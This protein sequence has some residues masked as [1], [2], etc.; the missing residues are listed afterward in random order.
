MV[1]F[2]FPLLTLLQP[3]SYP[4]PSISARIFTIPK[5]QNIHCWH[6]RSELSSLLIKDLPNCY[7]VRPLQFSNHIEMNWSFMHISFMDH[8][9]HALPTEKIFDLLK[10]IRSKSL[11][12]HYY[13]AELVFEMLKVIIKWLEVSFKEFNRQ[14]ETP[15]T[16]NTICSRDSV[17]SDRATC[18]I[19]SRVNFFVSNKNLG[20]RQLEPWCHDVDREAFHNHQM[21]YIVNI[22]AIFKTSAYPETLL[23][24]WLVNFTRVY[25]TPCC[26]VLH[27]LSTGMQL[28]VRTFFLVLCRPLR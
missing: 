26:S 25:S 4:V 15:Q 24:H 19:A 23:E 13:S 3:K 5:L 18:T 27:P 16:N 7:Y 1:E 12:R 21:L 8:I 11:L 14:L 9:S 17:P 22:P 10:S 6:L 20:V 2:P 28:T